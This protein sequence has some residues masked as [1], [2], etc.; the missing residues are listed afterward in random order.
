MEKRDEGLQACKLSVKEMLRGYRENL[1]EAERRLDAAQ[2][3][4]EAL[5]VLSWLANSMLRG[6][7]GIQ[8][9][10]PTKRN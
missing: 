1:T 10:N 2:T 8:G 4:N 3:V 9:S 6:P 5:Q 7:I